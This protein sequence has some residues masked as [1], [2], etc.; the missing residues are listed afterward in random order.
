MWTSVFLSFLVQRDCAHCYLL[1]AKETKKTM[2]KAASQALGRH[3]IA[4][5]YSCPPEALNG[6]VSIEEAMVQSAEKAGATV[7]NSTFHH[8]APMGVSGVVV[9]QESHLAI[10]TW[11][12]YGFAALDLFTCGDTVSPWVA[13]ETLRELLGAKHVSAIEMRRGQ[14]ELLPPPVPVE[15]GQGQLSGATVRKRTK[16]LWFT[17]RA[18]EIALSVKHEGE[19]LAQRQSAYQRIEVLKTKALGDMLVLD[20]VMAAT[21]LDG[22]AA[23]E[24]LVHPAMLLHSNPQSIV[25]IG[26]GDGGVVTEAL[27]HE[28]VKQVEVLEQDIA[29]METARQWLP[30]WA[31]ALG[32]SRVSCTVGEA[33]A[34]LQ[35]MPL[36]TVDVLMVDAYNPAQ[37]EDLQWESAFFE[38]VD[39]VLSYQG[40][41]VFQMGSPWVAQEEFQKRFQQL[42]RQF[43]KD[44]VHAYQASLP[45]YPTGHWIFA[46]ATKQDLKPSDIAQSEVENFVRNQKFQY[47]NQSLYL[48]VWSLPTFALRLLDKC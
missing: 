30:Q 44:R 20:G 11:P 6:V 46:I 31:E 35:R 42:Y 10:H 18:G 14:P 21:T 32:Q 15:Y 41:A 37:M 36:G 40:M 12:E 22:N 13:L 33:H 24:M 7:I 17:E 45:S 19:L 39:R 16:E 3:L 29:V 4:E 38:L 5:L 34:S 26:G 48:H 25:I 9:I 28:S 43:G 23:H 47:F 27:K 2:L 8:F 1:D